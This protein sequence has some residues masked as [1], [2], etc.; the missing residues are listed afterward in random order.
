MHAH[1]PQTMYVEILEL[2]DTRSQQHPTPQTLNQF[3]P[4]PT[5]PTISKPQPT[6][7]ACSCVLGE[8]SSLDNYGG[9][10][11]IGNR[12]N[13][14]APG[15]LKIEHFKVIHKIEQFSGAT[16]IVQAC[17]RRVVIFFESCMFNQ[18]IARIKNLVQLTLY[19][20]SARVFVI[21]RRSEFRMFIV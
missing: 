13:Y 17:A 6:Y 21:P 7:N 3:H 20:V 5:Q 15:N 2:E 4:C 19:C 16:Q 11:K 8:R 14:F 12:G 10:F 1:G 9:N 18:W